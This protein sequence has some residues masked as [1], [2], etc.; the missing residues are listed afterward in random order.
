MRY[1]DFLFIHIYACHYCSHNNLIYDVEK[2]KFPQNY[3]RLLRTPRTVVLFVLVCSF[4]DPPPPR[5]E[6]EFFV[7]G[8]FDEVADAVVVA[9]IVVV[10]DVVTAFPLL[11]DDV[12]LFISVDGGAL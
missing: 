1:K 4:A 10:G 11:L 9:G 3:L 7:A 12:T 8:G 5:F 2:K 6:P